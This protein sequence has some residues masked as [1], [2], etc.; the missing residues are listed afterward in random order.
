MSDKKDNPIKSYIKKDLNK[1]RKKY[2]ETGVKTTKSKILQSLVA[3]SEAGKQEEQ[4][5][6]VIDTVS[7]K[8][9]L[10][11][12]QESKNTKYK[13]HIAKKDMH[14]I[15]KEIDKRND[16]AGLEPNSKTNPKSYKAEISEKDKKVRW[17]KVAHDVA[18]PSRFASAGATAA[19]LQLKKQEIK[20]QKNR[21]N[22]DSIDKTKSTTIKAAS[23]ATQAP[24][25]ATRK[26]LDV[27]AAAGH[28]PEFISQPIAKEVKKIASKIKTH[29]KNNPRSKSTVIKSKKTGQSFER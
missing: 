28:V 7:Y 12:Y 22:L 20:L 9:T 11:R 19:S 6:G 15:E 3:G 18:V 1:E 25:L 21:D 10:G 17:G 2:K 5:K 8:V 23:Y 16:E 13:D 29:I 27:A 26:S 24:I 4:L 14:S